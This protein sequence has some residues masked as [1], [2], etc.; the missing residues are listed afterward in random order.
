MRDT[1][2][3]DRI[4]GRGDPGM[5][6]TRYLLPRLKGGRP[7]LVILVTLLG[8]LSVNTS[9]AATPTFTKSVICSDITSSPD[10][11]VVDF[12]GDGDPDV[13]VGGL[14]SIV[15]CVNG[16][17]GTFS[18]SVLVPSPGG[19][20]TK[21]TG[22]D[23]NGDG[24]MDLVGIDTGSDE[25][26]WW[27]NNGDGTFT[28]YVVGSSVGGPSDIVVTDLEND[29]DRDIITSSDLSNQIIWWRNDGAIQAVPKRLYISDRTTNNYRI[30]AVDPLTNSQVA[31]IALSSAHE[32]GDLAAS[33]YGK[34]LYAVA[35][36][37][38]LVIDVL[39]NAV[40]AT[41]SNAGG[42]G[43]STQLAIS[44]DGSKLYVASHR[45]TSS[46]Q[47]KV[48]N[49]TTSAVV[50]TI[51]DWAFNAC[52]SVTGFGIQPSGGSL[53]LACSAT[54]GGRGGRR[55]GRRGGTSSE[56]EFFVINTATDNVSKTA[57]FTDPSRNITYVNA[58]AVNPDGSEVYLVRADTSWRGSSAGAVE[59][60]R[61]SNGSYKQSINLPGGGTF[62]RERAASVTPAGDKLYVT[63]A[64]K[65]V[66]VIDLGTK[67]VTATLPQ[68][69]S[70][71]NDIAMSSDG[72]AVYTSMSG[73]VFVN[74]TASDSYQATVTGT[75]SNAYNLAYTPGYGG[76]EK[77]TKVI[78]TNWFQGAGSVRTVDL[79]NDGRLDV[80]GA[81]HSKKQI[82]WW[83][84][85]SDNSFTKFTIDT[86]FNTA[87]VVR[88]ADIDGDGWQDVIAT[89]DGS[90]GTSP[91]L[92]WWRN[93][94]NNTF[95]KHV[96]DGYSSS[97]VEIADLDN[98][99]HPDIAAMT[100]GTTQVLWWQ[101]DGSGTFTGNIADTSGGESAIELGD[102]DK[103]GWQDIVES[104][105]GKN[106]FWW[107]N[108]GAGAN[109]G[110]PFGF[111]AVEP[112]TGSAPPADTDP[113]AGKIHTKVDGQAFYLDLVAL[114]DA[115]N[116]GIADSVDTDYAIGGSHTLQLQVIS[117]TC[118]SY[119][120]IETLP[121][122]VFQQADQPAEQGRKQVCACG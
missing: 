50:A 113:L 26:V 81:A 68:S 110:I 57:T 71:G 82:A 19:N 6:L 18:S 101:N 40:T 79:N 93:N 75:F 48:I 89:G 43:N 60:F 70:N 55:G 83:R 86:A 38:V 77:F 112:Q 66:Y 2:Y 49:T 17:D 53:Y 52:T 106:I 73:N 9:R 15:L 116:N 94:H 98:D 105:T 51:T 23:V 1:T 107:H 74:D 3:C 61:G 13:L 27:G 115:D 58:M 111:N 63:D 36:S 92:V 8:M 76:G 109:T 33:P 100:Y 99:G 28:K 90:G 67:T 14:G 44:P 12:N 118:A 39:T 21:V 31:S 103:D 62:S 97:D 45:S 29:G 25:V 46:L 69:T 56:G 121:S 84:H 65:G 7:L 16:G 59:V 95:T 108:E 22:A 30:V 87:A 64:V 114:A 54:T 117:G 37:D 20:N 120:V 5:S 104:G 96:I 32:P 80:L 4:Q 11:S 35:G 122:V 102:F 72:S 119:S 78:I 91:G 42:D 10:I 47:I 85:N 24:K 41:V 88:A 34:K